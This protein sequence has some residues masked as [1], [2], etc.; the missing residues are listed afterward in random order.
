MVPIDS[1][2]KAP[3]ICY[4]LMACDLY[5]QFD[6]VVDTKA[7]LYRPREGYTR[8]PGVL[9]AHGDKTALE[10][11]WEY[12]SRL[13]REYDTGVKKDEL[14]ADEMLTRWASLLPGQLTADTHSRV[15]YIDDDPDTRSLPAEVIVV[16]LPHEGRGVMSSQGRDALRAANLNRSSVGPTD[17]MVWDFDCTLTSIHLYKTLYMRQTRTPSAQ[18]TSFERKWG[19]LLSDWWKIQCRMANVQQADVLGK[20]KRKVEMLARERQEERVKAEAEAKRQEEERVKAEAEAVAKRAEA[21]AKRKT[22]ERLRAEAEA[23]RAEAE[24]KRKTEERSR[25]EAEAKRQAEARLKAEAEAKYVQYRSRLEEQRP[26][27]IVEATMR[28]D[29]RVSDQWLYISYHHEIAWFHFTWSVGVSFSLL[30]F[31][32]SNT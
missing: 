11:A 9:S 31:I 12:D 27:S 7:H 28:N 16:Q 1:R 26:R 4:V 25:A 10:A 20:L 2:G 32:L 3:D 8:D 19:P 18:K 29:L 24:A 30:C 22:E 23:R 6:C 5:D 15:V 14:I 21:E 13:K 17:I